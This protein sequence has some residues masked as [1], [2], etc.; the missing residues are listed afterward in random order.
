MAL[1]SQVYLSTAAAVAGDKATPDQSI[2]TPYNFLAESDVSVGQFVFR[3]ATDGM[4][5]GVDGTAA[6]LLGFVERVINYPNY[7]VTE[8]GTL[9]VPNGF[10]LTVAVQGDYYVSAPYAVSIGDSVTIDS[11]GALVSG[12]SISTGWVYKTAGAE[13]DLVIISNWGVVSS[14]GGSGDYMAA[15]FSNA[16]GVLGVSHGG[17]GATTEVGL[18]SDIETLLGLGGLATKDQVDLSSDVTGVLGVAS[19]GTGNATGNA[20]SADKLST[21]RTIT[22]TGAVSGSAGFDGS[23]DVTINTTGE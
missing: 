17:T 14:G 16:T 8:E 19:G 21:E 6:T 9:V 2:Y 15:D 11:T 5:T 10:P 18:K 7:T 3:S 1:Q 12:G 22:L 20:A 13:G 23:A 4:A